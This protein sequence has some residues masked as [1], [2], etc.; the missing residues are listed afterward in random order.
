MATFSPSTHS[1]GP[2]RSALVSGAAASDADW[3]CTRCG[4]LLGIQRDGRVHLSFA[5]GHE[6]LASFPVQAT[7][8]KCGTLNELRDTTAI[9]F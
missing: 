7:C 4:K 9:P 8:R 1:T 2:D 3:R 6:Y 5:R